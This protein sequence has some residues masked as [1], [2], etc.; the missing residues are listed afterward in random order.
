MEV[1]KD[2]RIN[3]HSLANIAPNLRALG[4]LRH[5]F[6]ENYSSAV[7]SRINRQGRYYIYKRMFLCLMK[8][9]RCDRRAASRRLPRI[10]FRNCADTQSALAIKTRSIELE[11]LQICAAW[12]SIIKFPRTRSNLPQCTGWGGRWTQHP[13]SLGLRIAWR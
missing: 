12:F 5:L 9:R 7:G 4:E 3:K 6:T 1:I 11:T 2:T 8:T 13:D 10:S